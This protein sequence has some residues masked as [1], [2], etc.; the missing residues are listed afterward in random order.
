MRKH[1]RPAQ[2][3]AHTYFILK[4]LSVNIHSRL[5][6]SFSFILFDIFLSF[7]SGVCFIWSSCLMRLLVCTRRH[8][9]TH[10]PCLSLFPCLVCDSLLK[11]CCCIASEDN[12]IL[13]LL[14]FLT[15]SVFTCEGGLSWSVGIQAWSF[16]T[17]FQCVWALEIFIA[18]L[19]PWQWEQ[20]GLS[21]LSGVL[22]CT[23][24]K[25]VKKREEGV[26]M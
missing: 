20:W 1:E 14:F 6:H 23:H 21:A 12:L 18:V 24:S 25:G 8:K 22:V 3:W 5:S 26:S 4:L 13:L 2:A 9:H 10:T 17:F 19:L 7:D 11:A 16:S 15:P